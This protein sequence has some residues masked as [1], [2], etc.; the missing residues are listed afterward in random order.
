M[1]MHELGVRLHGVALKLETDHLPLLTYAAEHLHGLVDATLKS[2]DIVVKCFWSQ[3]DEDPETNPFAP[4]SGAMNVIGKR[5]LG[6]AEELIWLDTL[7]M[8]G[9]QLRFRRENGRFVFDVA[10]R[11]HP[12]KEKAE[13]LPEYEYKRYFSLMSYLVYYPLIWHLERFR[14]WTILHASALAFDQLTRPDASLSS[15]SASLSSSSVSLSSGSVSLSSAGGILIGGLGGVGK[16]TTCVALMQRPGVALMS[17]NIIFTDGEFIYPCYEPIRLDAGSLAMLGDLGERS[18]ERSR[19]SLGRAE[20]PLGLIRMAFPEGLKDKWLFHLKKSELPPKI[21]PRWM[22]L[23]QFSSRRYLKALAPELAAEKIQAMN[24]LTRELDDYGWY[25]AAL[26]MHWPKAGQ[27]RNR[28][29]VLRRFAQQ[30]RCYELGIDRSA[31]VEAVVEDI[32][33]TIQS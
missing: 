29:E 3:E 20:N 5:M 14:G 2:P 9:L 31:G 15:S 27:A 25:A 7:R 12:K 32:F 13:N 8:K 6:N 23:P 10:Y 30:V 24:R 11:F 16:T 19:R 28:V 18:T 17:E 21:K 33:K 1:Q 22:F 26:D 4:Q